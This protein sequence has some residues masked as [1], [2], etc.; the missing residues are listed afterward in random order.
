MRTMRVQP[1]PDFPA[2]PQ[3][4]NFICEKVGYAGNGSRAMS[5]EQAL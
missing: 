2:L 5:A 1:N 3:R 4:K